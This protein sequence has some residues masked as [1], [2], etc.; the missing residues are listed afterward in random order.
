MLPILK[1]LQRLH[2]SL[3]VKPKTSLWL[4]RCKWSI[5][6]Q[7]SSLVFCPPS[8]FN[9]NTKPPCNLL[10]T[11]GQVLPQ[12]LCNCCLHWWELSPQGKPGSSPHITQTLIWR[13]SLKALSQWDISS[14]Q[15]LNVKLLP[16]SLTDISLLS[17][18]IF[19]TFYYLTYS[20]FYLWFS[21]LSPWVECR[22]LKAGMITATSLQCL[23]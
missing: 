6:S 10:F 22:L 9:G 23:E 11:Q 17:A 13:S 12:G 3:K 4:S 16:P 18:H 15:D 5:T 21:F 8:F 19:R 20:T 1:P 7:S 14:T 2:F